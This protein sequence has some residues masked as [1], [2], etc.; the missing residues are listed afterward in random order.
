V[1]LRELLTTAAADL[2]DVTTASSPEGE[3]AWSRGA[4]LFATLRGDGSAAEFKLDSAVAAAAV[5]T[6]DTVPSPRG[7]GW[8]LFRPTTLDAHGADRAAAWFVS[9][10]RLARKV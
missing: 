3:I 8:V 4:D 2:D 10:C 7:S 1:T 9:A 6:P 5:R